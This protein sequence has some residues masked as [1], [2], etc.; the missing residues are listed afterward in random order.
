MK[1]IA[2]R[3]LISLSFLFLAAGAQAQQYY[4]VVG[5]FAKESN[6]EKFTG[7]VRSLRYAANYELN[8]TKNYFYVY[9]LRTSKREA[10]LSQVTELQQESEFKDAWL[11]FGSLGSGEVIIEPEVVQVEP[12][13]EEVPDVVQPDT[14]STA[15]LFPSTTT[16]GTTPAKVVKG[17]LFKFVIQTTDGK[18]IHGSVHHVDFNRGRDIASYKAD[19]YIDMPRPSRSNNPM[20]LVCGIFG[21]KELVKFVNYDEPLADESIVKDDKNAWV[22]NFELERLKKGDVSVMYH[23]SF[24]KDA[25]VMLPQSKEEL[26]ELVSMMTDNPNYKIK[27][28]GHCNG[29]NSRKIIALGQTKNY[30]SIQ[31]SDERNGTAKELSKLRA[32][33]VQAY[34]SDN[35]IARDRSEVF[36]WGALS[37]LVP[38]TSTSARLNDRI[39]IEI[40]QN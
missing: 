13:K 17:K 12:V 19:E 27:I 34:L 20:S 8:K 4:V 28:H 31:G 5:A 22:V 33:A 38:E 11:F 29:N 40:R 15:V 9:V 36:A 2:T 21:Y 37:M 7:Y 30:F 39:E 32:E 14:V 23:V 6:A 3:Y 25:V 1:K 35:G 16:N 10:G 18:L 26:D 24:Y